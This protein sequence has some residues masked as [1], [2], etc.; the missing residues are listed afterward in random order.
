MK[1]ETL[2]REMTGN[3]MKDSGQVKRFTT[4]KRNREKRNSYGSGQGETISLL[5]CLFDVS[6][7][8]FT[9]RSKLRKMNKNSG[10]R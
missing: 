5:I 2:E 7:E 1:R 4:K 9:L 8:M 6:I 3:E 10:D